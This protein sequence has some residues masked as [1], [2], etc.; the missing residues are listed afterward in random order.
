VTPLE[1]SLSLH[2]AAL[3]ILGALIVGLRHESTWLPGLAAIAAVASIFLTDAWRLVQLNRWL[4]NLITVA[5]V[6]W[7]LRDF[8]EI[9]SEDKLMAI[10]SMLCYLQI[11]LLFQAKTSRIYWQLVVLSV[12]QVVV[13][14]ALELGA[15][16]VPLIVLFFA[17]GLATLVLLCVHREVEPTKRM[18]WRVPFAWPF[19]KSANKSGDPRPPATPQ[20]AMA[21]ILRA[22]PSV[23]SRAT[24]E[25]QLMQLFT[26]R[27]LL[28]Q[29]AL[30]AVLTV[31]FTLAFFYATPRLRD[32][33]PGRLGSGAVS[34]FRPE[35]RLERKGRIHMSSRPVMRTALSRLSDR[36]PIELISPPYYHGA[37]LTDYVVDD[38]GSRWLPLQS[39]GRT[40]RGALRA[41][42][43]TG[44]VS[45]R[46]DIAVESNVSPRFTIQPIHALPD[47]MTSFGSGGRSRSENSHQQRYAWG[48]AAI[49]NERQLYGI[50][51]PNRRQLEMEESAFEEELGRASDFRFDRF[52][53]LAATAAEIIEQNELTDGQAF[54]K[55]I[56][57]SRHFLAP[58]QYQYSLNLQITAD[59]NIDPI[60]DFVATARTGNCEYFA[61]AMALMLRSQHI[62]ARLV[63]GYKG[64]T[65][66]S[67]GHYYLVQERDAHTWVEAWFPTD[68]VPATEIAG[69]PSDG[70]I[71]YRFDPTPSRD[72]QVVL[73]APDWK[74]KA[75]QAFDYVE[76]LWRDYVLSLNTTRQDEIVFDPLTARAG[77]LPHWVELR[78]VSRWLRRTGAALGGNAFARGGRGARVFEGS[79]AVAVVVLLV[80]LL[81]MTAVAR[82]SWFV[83]RRWI[84]GRPRHTEVKSPAFYRRL[85][86][87]L[88]RAAIV[89]KSGQTPRELAATARQRLH[90]LAGQA[91]V[92]ALPDQLVTAYYRVRFGDGRLDKVETEAIEQ[93]LEEIESVFKHAKRR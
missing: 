29:T 57:I 78:E 26:P 16:F 17:V 32:F 28:R 85:E 64:G 67:V 8:L 5:A 69:A 13:A 19:F 89:R 6:G 42:Q 62:P 4:A 33:A 25:C 83:L 12:L 35:V 3:T 54:E 48:T 93:A 1:R 84:T 41:V 91:Q 86:R 22:P 9:S 21:Q 39:S 2:V 34:G 60:E 72:N 77:A 20:V 30:L 87:L 58:G 37:I 51:N 76:L 66:N 90:V 71:W 7:S 59:T 46:Q 70:G 56:A 14:A 53:K 27:L 36:K 81:V 15:Q 50:P 79:A 23:E 82:W 55:A 40:S 68:E 31:L 38:Y 18:Q 74:D 75:A 73:Q 45:V 10:G 63:R 43:T 80:G 52:P 11:G 24:D 44:R 88:R 65:Y 49:V 61:S 47:A 92:T